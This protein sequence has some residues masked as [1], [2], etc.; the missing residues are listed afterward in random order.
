[1]KSVET[2]CMGVQ[3]ATGYD[4]DSSD[5][6]ANDWIILENEP[7][8]FNSGEVPRYFRCPRCNELSR[9]RNGTKDG[10]VITCNECNMKV[11][12]KEI[13]VVPWKNI[14]KWF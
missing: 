10:A 5:L 12:Y 13:G 4:M 2:G 8:V 14:K 6:F 3:S 7:I 1:M 9:I 11:K